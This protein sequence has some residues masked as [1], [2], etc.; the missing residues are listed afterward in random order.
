MLRS[1]AVHSFG[2]L[3]ALA[4]VFSVLA[5]RH[6]VCA[7]GM[8]FALVCAWVGDGH[9]RAVAQ[10]R[11]SHFASDLLRGEGCWEQVYYRN[12]VYILPPR[13]DPTYTGP[14]GAQILAYAERVGIQ[15]STVV[16]HDAPDG[17][18][19]KTTWPNGD[20]SYERRVACPEQ[21]AA[22]PPP[23]AAPPVEIPT[24][25]ALEPSTPGPVRPTE[26]TAYG[27][28]FGAPNVTA[29][30]DVVITDSM[31]KVTSPTD[32]IKT[33]SNT[34]Q[35]QFTAQ[36]NW[37]QFY[38]SGAAR[39]TGDTRGSFS[40]TFFG[41]PIVNTGTVSSGS[42][43]AFTTSAGYNLINLPGLTAGLFGVYYIDVEAL[44]GTTMFSGPGISSLLETRSQAA[45]AGFY[46]TE[47]FHSGPLVGTL[48]AFAA[49]LADDVKSGTFNGNGPGWQAN[50]KLTIPVGPV[51]V[52]LFGQ[53]T[54]INA[55]GSPM[56]VPLTFKNE[57]WTFGAGLSGSW[58][59]PH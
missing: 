13:Y 50:A 53:F 34:P 14:T 8:L 37:G 20:V 26:Q 39:G 2:R 3:A 47:N 4:S 54:D 43:N 28:P 46:L 27:G 45:G 18:D 11:V 23:A 41:S 58:G 12:G 21:A 10:A 44:Y 42:N 24:L 52:N 40:D 5:K 25:P 7:F 36:I 38:W 56:G 29:T 15:V 35:L 31:W 6:T 9:L 59:L 30:T 55:S 22:Q 33:T 32:Q 51:H 16:D 48:S 1:A 57:S 49:Y 19:I 17:F